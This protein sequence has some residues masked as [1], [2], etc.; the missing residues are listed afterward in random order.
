M[1]IKLT[2]LY[3]G[4][5][6]ALTSFVA[7]PVLADEWNKRTEFQFS[8][9]VQIPG[10]TLAAGKYVF[11]LADSESDRNIVQVFS[12]DSVGRETLVATLMAVPEY[13]EQTPDKAIVHFEE[14]PSGSPEA[15]RSWFYP[16]ENTGWEFVYPQNPNSRSGLN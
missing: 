4:G 10:K 9:P 16:G 5:F 12:E 6:F 2:T 7:R 8:A 1:N 3:L 14:R 15:I 11:Q 13:I